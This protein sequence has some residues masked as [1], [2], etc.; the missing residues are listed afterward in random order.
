MLPPR[1]TTGSAGF[2]V[3]SSHYRVPL[4]SSLHIAKSTNRT[5]NME[6]KITASC[7]GFD[8]RS[9]VVYTCKWCRG[10]SNTE[11]VS[12]R[13]W[14]T[15]C[16]ARSDTLQTTTFPPKIMTGNRLFC[17][18]PVHCGEVRVLSPLS[19]GNWVPVGGAR[20]QAIRLGHARYVA[21]LRSGF[22]S[23]SGGGTSTISAFLRTGPPLR[24]G[25]K[26]KAPAAY[27]RCQY[28]VEIEVRF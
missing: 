27:C 4:L 1:L 20:A 25:V 26:E 12:E 10:H 14:S 16:S 6:L 24:G 3:P 19:T 21:N 7:P 2:I 15:P 5:L 18:G 8:R 9:I 13:R 17:A 28:S 22:D 11:F 23:G